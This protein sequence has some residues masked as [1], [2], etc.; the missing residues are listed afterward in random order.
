MHLVSFDK[1]ILVQVL[2]AKM[3][4]HGFAEVSFLWLGHPFPFRS[5]CEKCKAG[6]LLFPKLKARR[7]IIDIDAGVVNRTLVDTNQSDVLISA[8]DY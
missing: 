5:S 8:S 7:R 1:V 2:S 6:T 3:V 4:L